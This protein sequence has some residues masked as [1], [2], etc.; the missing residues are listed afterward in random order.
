MSQQ[1]AARSPLSVI[2]LLHIA[3][4]APL[5]IQGVWSP[6]ALPFLQMNNSTVVILKLYAA[7]ILGTCVATFLAYPLP[8]FLPGKRAL[9]IGLCIYHS[10]VSTVL[11]Q[12]PRFI[13]HSFGPFMEQM[14][15]TPEVVWGTLHGFIGLGMV[16]WWQGTLQYGAMARRMQ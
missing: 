3:L 12:S 5:A 16:A 13:P 1:V 9:A 2:F 11:F 15:L 8:E 7:L 10:V 6:Q 4:E 14:K